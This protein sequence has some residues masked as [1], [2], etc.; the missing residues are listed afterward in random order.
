V[1]IAGLSFRIEAHG[2]Y[3]EVRPS[4]RLHASATDYWDGNWIG[5]TVEISAGKFR[6]TYAAD[7]RADEFASFRDNLAAV[8]ENLSGTA[9]FES[10]EEWIRIEASCDRKG[11]FTAACEVT[12]LPGMGA[13]LRFNLSFDQTQIPKMI[14]A[15]DAILSDFPVLGKP[16][17]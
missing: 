11:H 14:A 13:R 16:T 1:S 2:D 8:Y 10:M 15:L 3:L 9:L 4:R 6:A 7:L 12:D 5:C 17:D